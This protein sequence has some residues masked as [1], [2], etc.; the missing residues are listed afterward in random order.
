MAV[1]IRTPGTGGRTTATET[2]AHAD[3]KARSQRIPATVR[4]NMA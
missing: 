3:Q 2:T 1:P 4:F